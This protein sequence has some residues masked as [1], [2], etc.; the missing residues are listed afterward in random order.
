MRT[1]CSITP[2]LNVILTSAVLV[3]ISLLTTFNFPF[4]TLYFF[5]IYFTRFV[6]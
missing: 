1:I 5:F 3:I 2:Q 6:R 4:V